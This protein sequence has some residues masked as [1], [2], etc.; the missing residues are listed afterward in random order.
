MEKMVLIPQDQYERSKS[1]NDPKGKKGGEPP[2]VRLKLLY[3]EQMKKSAR[4]KN[5]Q[6]KEL[7]RIQPLLALQSSNLAEVLRNIPQGKQLSANFILRILSRL[8]KVS[9]VRNFITIDGEPLNDTASQIVEQIIDNGV[10]GTE[11]VIQAL[12]KG[13][14]TYPKILPGSSSKK[15]P[16][17]PL[18]LPLTQPSLNDSKDSFH[19]FSE[20][21][22]P[23][24]PKSS[25]PKR[26]DSRY[27]STNEDDDWSDEDKIIK[28]IKRPN[29]GRSPVKGSSP[30][31]RY[32]PDRPPPRR[33]PVK[34]PAKN[35]PSK[36]SGKESPM[37]LRLNPKK[38][39]KGAHLTPPKSKKTTSTSSP[40]SAFEKLVDKRKER[41]NGGQKWATFE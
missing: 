22:T 30:K 41:E 3:D 26:N 24:L 8:P 5:K 33:S 13:H 23:Y 37:K 18:S 10:I 20:E 11:H 36:V 19:S 7:D 35:P 28:S 17:P 15:K 21:N 25:T 14:L 27:F 34:S 40:K 12:R 9:I 4:E 16:N 29:L 31:K 32:R 38:T 6:E 2:D 39:L 1:G